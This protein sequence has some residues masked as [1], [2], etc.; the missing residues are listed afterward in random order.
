MQ[1]SGSMEGLK[2]CGLS[3]I[4]KAGEVDGARLWRITL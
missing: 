1:R 4:I 3:V 2:S